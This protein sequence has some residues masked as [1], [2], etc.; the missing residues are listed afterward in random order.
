MQVV[1]EVS[2]RGPMVVL[3]VGRLLGALGAS[4]PSKCGVG[5]RAN[6]ARWFHD[7]RE[8][9]PPARDSVAILGHAI[10]DPAVPRAV[11][12]PRVPRP[13]KCLDSKDLAADALLGV[14][15]GK[16]AAHGRRVA[17]CARR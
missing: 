8:D 2:G 3:L 4:P 13:A 7:H 10:L 14:A 5:V 1:G 9:N 16:G 11:V 6:G 12:E 15:K 17:L